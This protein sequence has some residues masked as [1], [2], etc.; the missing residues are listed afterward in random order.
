MTATREAG[1]RRRIVSLYPSATETLYDLGLA[2]AVAGRTAFCPAPAGIPA[3][4]ALGGPKNPEIDRIAALHPDLVVACI[5]ENR[6]EDVEK[7]EA[8]APVFVTHPRSVEDVRLLVERLGET[9][10]A[11]PDRI[12]SLT[13][14]ISTRLRNLRGRAQPR[15]RALTFIWRNPWWSFGGGTYASDLLAVCG[16]D[17]VFAADPR[18]YF[19][20][21][22]A[23]IAGARPDILL[24]PDE[25]FPFHQEHLAPILEEF[26][27]FRGLPHRFFDGSLL[28][29]HGSRTA[30]ALEL[31]PGI[32]G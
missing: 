13:D 9:A 5:D 10:G 1:A 4:P 31:L 16:L 24:F 12:G 27:A 3:P 23:L 26:P 32:L 21:E 14:A 17:N 6:R 19:A 2:A 7:I 25:P 30:R 11:A 20:V 18:P 15:R 29:W 8:F 22:P 28:T